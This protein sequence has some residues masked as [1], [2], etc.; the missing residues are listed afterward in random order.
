ME[1]SRGRRRGKSIHLHRHWPLAGYWLRTE[2]GG[3]WRRRG[4]TLRNTAPSWGSFT[5]I[6][7]IDQMETRTDTRWRTPTSGGVAWGSGVGQWVGWVMRG[8]GVDLCSA[9]DDEDPPKNIRDHFLSRCLLRSVRCSVFLTSRTC[10][11]SII[12]QES[13]TTF[14]LLKDF[15]SYF[16]IS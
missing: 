10:F 14:W 8:G 16:F 13:P 1:A 4:W 3:G 9:V 7:G 2:D 6:D 5:L 15:I 11:I 12:W